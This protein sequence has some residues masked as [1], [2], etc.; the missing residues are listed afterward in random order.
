ME[1]EKLEP[2]KPREIIN[3]DSKENLIKQ[4]PE[5]SDIIEKMSDSNLTEEEFKKIAHE[6]NAT[7]DT[8]PGEVKRYSLTLENGRVI[9][10]CVGDD[11]RIGINYELL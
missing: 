7:A 3:V 10:V 11:G 4:F 9:E 8:P 6:Y 5:A 2:K 1:F